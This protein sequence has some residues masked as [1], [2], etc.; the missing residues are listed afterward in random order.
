MMGDSGRFQTYMSLLG[1]RVIL[2]HLN[3][4]NRS[5]RFLNSRNNSLQRRR[6]T[7][8]AS[9]HNE[10]LHTHKIYTVSDV[11]D[12]T[13]DNTGLAELD[14]ILRWP[15]LA[16]VL[17]G[18]L[19]FPIGSSKA[20]NFCKRQL[21]QCGQRKHRVAACS[22]DTLDTYQSR[23]LQRAGLSPDTVLLLRG[24]PIASLSQLGE[25]EVVT[26]RFEVERAPTSTPRQQQRNGGALD[27]A[28]AQL[29]RENL[30]QVTTPPRG[31]VILSTLS[32]SLA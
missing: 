3:R 29:T 18:V 27:P 31:R 19:M 25:G 26:C 16:L 23:A 13:G 11:G 17:A 4:F 1:R 30:V 5:C 22:G 8:H 32:P 14:M 9:K 7:L 12:A 28:L 15:W 24:A 2:I 21:L 6:T 20:R 10:R